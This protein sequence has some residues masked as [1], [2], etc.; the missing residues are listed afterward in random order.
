MTAKE[1]D[2]KPASDDAT[3]VPAEATEPEQLKE[4][5]ALLE[6]EAAKLRDQWIRAA[7]ETENVRKRMARDQEDISRYAVTGFAR[8][9]VSVLEN[10][11]RASGSIPQD[12]RR[13]DELLNVLA[14]GVDLTLKEMLSIFEK[15]GIQRI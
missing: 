2:P 11:K 3:H 9:M 7:A 6:E 12:A 15:Y 5:I 8:E 10:L 4:K 1:E 13:T 14:E